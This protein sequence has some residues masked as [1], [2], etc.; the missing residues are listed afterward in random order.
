MATEAMDPADPNSGVSRSLTITGQK[1]DGMVE[2]LKAKASMPLLTRSQS[3]L[4]DVRH[5][6]GSESNGLYLEASSLERRFS[7]KVLDFLFKKNAKAKTIDAGYGRRVDVTV[8]DADVTKNRGPSADDEDRQSL[9]SVKSNS[10][11]KSLAEGKKGLFNFRTKKSKQKK[12][13]D[14]TPSISAISLVTPSDGEKEAWLPSPPVASTTS[15]PSQSL[16]PESEPSISTERSQPVTISSPSSSLHL[17]TISPVSGSW[18]WVSA[19]SQTHPGQTDIRELRISPRASSLKL[20]E[21][22]ASTSIP[23]PEKQETSAV[24]PNGWSA[25]KKGDESGKDISPVDGPSLRDGQEQGKEEKPEPADRADDDELKRKSTARSNR[26]TLSDGTPVV[27]DVLSPPKKPV[28]SRAGATIETDD[29]SHLF[30][31]P[32]HLH[33]ELHPNDFKKWLNNADA[34]PTDSTVFQIGKKPLRRSKSFVERHVVITPDNV[35]EFVEKDNIVRSRTVSGAQY[36]R[37]GKGLPPLRR[38]RNIRPKR[39]TMRSMQESANSTADSDSGPDYA[40]GTSKES[41]PVRR[42]S[43]RKADRSSSSVR[44]KKAGNRRSKTIIMGPVEERSLTA[45][46]EIPMDPSVSALEKQD[47]DKVSTSHTFSTP[48]PVE[49]PKP[50][51]ELKVDAILAGDAYTHPASPEPSFH[52][53]SESM[54]PDDLE[55]LDVPQ[56]E[57][58]STT[59]D[60][61]IGEKQKSKKKKEGKSWNWLSGF[62]GKKSPGSTKHKRAASL[63]SNGSSAAEDDTWNAYPNDRFSDADGAPRF[64]PE[65]EKQIYRMSHIKLAQHRRPLSQQVLISNLMLYILSVHADVT[66]NR[67]GPRKRGRKGRRRGKSPG[68]SSDRS[69]SPG[70]AL[71]IPHPATGPVVQPNSILEAPTMPRSGQYFPGAPGISSLTGIPGA[72][73]GDYVTDGSPAQGYFGNGGDS[74]GSERRQRNLAHLAV[75]KAGGIDSGSASSLEPAWVDSEYLSS[76]HEGDPSPRSRSYSPDR[77]TDSEEEEDEDDVPLGMLQQHRRGSISSVSSH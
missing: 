66:L 3:E 7:G 55:I 71:P 46:S 54:T 44:K 75:I 63:E 58:A 8:G 37:G 50:P 14:I 51:L 42:R 12:S 9:R 38:S 45:P 49:L 52:S 17:P 2:K 39:P 60:T 35:E 31:V 77:A 1:S 73:S 34:G 21:K 11:L 30:W 25:A 20:L 16:I 27:P 53:P 10:S 6:E 18:S 32:A 48:T 4:G 76:D 36:Q 15:N 47:T 67:Q 5:R 57:M 59:E 41:G 74:H 69:R 56:D 64:S 22:L 28:V 33:P 43:R 13:L 23:H 29:P 26:S 40:D 24:L 70:R 65:V 61:A 72:A 68:A 62:L 19:E